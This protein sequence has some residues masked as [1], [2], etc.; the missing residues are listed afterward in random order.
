M[1]AGQ[2]LLRLCELQRELLPVYKVPPSGGSRPAGPGGGSL[3]HSP[4]WFRVTYSATPWPEP[5]FSH[6]CNGANGNTSPS[7]E[8]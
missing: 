4:V 6:L 2:V 8:P 3:L 1:P 5:L 7:E